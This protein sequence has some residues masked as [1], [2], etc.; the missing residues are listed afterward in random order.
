MSPIHSDQKDYHMAMPGISVPISRMHVRKEKQ[1]TSFI[2]LFFKK[3][4]FICMP[5]AEINMQKPTCK[6]MI[7][8]WK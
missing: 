8:I 7:Y 2:Q 3:N 5:I 1:F 4:G 6:F